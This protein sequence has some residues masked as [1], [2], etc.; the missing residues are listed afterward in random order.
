[1][2]GAMSSA[3]IG[4]NEA[5]ELE[6]LFEHVGEEVFVLT[7]KV[8]VDA[9]IRAHDGAGW[10]SVTPISKASRSDSRA[11]RFEML[12]LTELRPLS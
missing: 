2:L 6:I 9:V 3:P 7:G 11:A 8:A 1:M 10:P 4:K 5:G 12:T